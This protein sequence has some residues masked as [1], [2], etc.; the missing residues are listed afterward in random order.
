MTI[1]T[2]ETG[3]LTCK[4]DPIATAQ[5]NLHMLWYNEGCVQPCGQWIDH[6]HCVRIANTYSAKVCHYEI[7]QN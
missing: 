2:G 1:K 7:P 4:V 5:Y 6:C 3:V